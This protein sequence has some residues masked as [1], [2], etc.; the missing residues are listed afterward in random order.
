MHVFLSKNWAQLTDKE[1]IVL[2]QMALYRYSE[3]LGLFICLSSFDLKL[4]ELVT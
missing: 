2:N 4:H 1:G 3:R